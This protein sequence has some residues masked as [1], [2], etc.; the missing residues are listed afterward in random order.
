MSVSWVYLFF[1][2]HQVFRVNPPLPR[3]TLSFFGKVREN[4]GGQFF[5]FANYKQSKKLNAAS[6]KAL[7]VSQHLE[8]TSLTPQQI[9]M[10]APHTL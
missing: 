4:L 1:F 2:H 5:A 8:S 10:T 6:G 3:L 7:G 9:S